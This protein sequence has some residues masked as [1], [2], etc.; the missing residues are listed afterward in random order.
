MSS[1]AIPLNILSG[2]SFEAL[3]RF[4]YAALEPAE[5]ALYTKTTSNRIVD[6]AE[7]P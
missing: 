6:Q 7:C 4:N 2:T 5:P 3:A 1:S